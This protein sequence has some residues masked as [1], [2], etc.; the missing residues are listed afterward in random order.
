MAVS[1]IRFILLAIAVA[2][3]L[4]SGSRRTS[5]DDCNGD[6]NDL[7]AQCL[8][9]VQNPGPEVPPSQACCDVIKRVNIPCVCQHVTK[10]IEKAISM[11]KV[12]YVASYCHRPLASGSKCGS[13]DDL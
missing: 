8:K 5:A 4:L 6:I 7:I 2:G 11:E 3:I 12:V 10:D 1:N 13:K 9:Y